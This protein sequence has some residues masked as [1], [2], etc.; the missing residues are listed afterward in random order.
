MIPRW[1]SSTLYKGARR[2]LRGRTAWRSTSLK[3]WS[4]KA[5]NWQLPSPRTTCSFR[6]YVFSR[7]VSRW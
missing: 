1:A 2:G 3:N 4:A 7:A 5:R 6:P